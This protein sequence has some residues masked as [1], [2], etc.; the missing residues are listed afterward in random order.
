LSNLTASTGA[1]TPAFDP[2][3]SAYAQSV[4]NSVTDLS[5]TPTSADAGA[6]IQVRING[7]T[8]STVLSGDPSPTLS[9]D[10]GA[11]PIDVQVTA[12]DTTTTKTYTSP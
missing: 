4:V 11:N 7:G 12:A 2:G 5:V 8:W 9:L 1:F 6:N 3:T 10:P